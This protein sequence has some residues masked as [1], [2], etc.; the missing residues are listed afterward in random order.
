MFLNSD[1]RKTFV[2]LSVIGFADRKGG[3]VSGLHEGV[4]NV[5]GCSRAEVSYPKAGHFSRLIRQGLVVQHPA[6]PNI[7]KKSSLYYYRKLSSLVFD[8]T[9][10][11]DQASCQTKHELK[12]VFV[13]LQKAGH[14]SCLNRQ[15]LMIQHPAKPNIN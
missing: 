10:A 8:S 5:D 2:L 13:L 12:V 11:H 4:P 1:D 9:A 14:F 6:K 7:N 3:K 15:R